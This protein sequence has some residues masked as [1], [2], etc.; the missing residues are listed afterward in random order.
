M[1]HVVNDVSDIALALGAVCSTEF[2]D[3]GFEA[4]LIEPGTQ[5]REVC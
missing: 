2:R 5:R 4:V 1:S 3:N